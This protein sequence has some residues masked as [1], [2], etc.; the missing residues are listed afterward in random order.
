M[1][2]SSERARSLA[3]SARGPTVRAAAAAPVG[4]AAPAIAVTLWLVA[5]AFSVAELWMIAVTLDRPAPDQWGFRGFEAVL[6]LS[7]GS[8]GA[9]VAARR[10]ENR[11]GWF[12]LGLMVIGAPQGVVDQYPVLAEASDPTLPFADLSR[13]ITAWIW[14]IPSVGLMVGLPLLFPTGRLLSPR[15]RPAVLLGVAAVVAQVGLIVLTSQ[16]LGPVPPGPNPTR[17]FERV[18]PVMAIGYLIE[19][20]AIVVAMSSAVVRYRQSRGDER[21]QIKWV[22]YAA[23]FVPF[24]AAA[25]FSGIAAGQLVLI[26]A[27]FF[28][29]AAMAIAILRYGLYEIDLIINRTLVYGALSAVLAGVYTASITL[30]QRVFMAVTGERSD[31]A[32]VLTTLIVAATF[33]PLKA[34]L[35]AVVDRRVK[36]AGP[37]EPDA[38]ASAPSLA[39]SGATVEVLVKLA[40]LRDAGA[41]TTDEFRI[42]KAAVLAHMGAPS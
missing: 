23:F 8:V 24:A 9:L 36:A 10:P 17:Y 21:Q 2:S 32:I 13:W 42:A 14:V 33:T 35:Q 37:A 11:F 5:V 16:P 28:A 18:G 3:R 22:A 38:V 30:S 26:A 31:A 4:R 29:A 34:R 1:A 15:W 20:S 39:G 19:L 41:L 12:V 27:A 40:A 6:T 7:F 25:G